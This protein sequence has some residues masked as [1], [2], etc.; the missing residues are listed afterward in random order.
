MKDPV[1]KMKRQII[2][3]RNIFINHIA[4]QRPIASLYKELSK[5]NMKK[6]TDQSE[7]GPSHEQIFH[8]KEN[9]GTPKVVQ[10]H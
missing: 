6:N 10:T 8:Q 5:L 3:W 7:N 1:K 2:D 4:N 9:T